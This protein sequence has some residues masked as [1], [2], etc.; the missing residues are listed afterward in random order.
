MEL[1][2]QRPSH[3]YRKMKA[4]VAGKISTDV[5]RTLWFQ[6]V[7]QR[8]QIVLAVSDDEEMS[9]M[10]ATADKIQVTADKHK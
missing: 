6:R 8:I 2:D 10:T 7:L 5:L 4:L 3:L 9:K 1:S